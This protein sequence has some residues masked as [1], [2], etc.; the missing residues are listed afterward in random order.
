MKLTVAIPIDVDLGAYAAELRGLEQIMIDMIAEPALMHRL[1]THIREAVLGAIDQV[2]ATGLLT[3]NNSGAMTCSDPIGVP[4]NGR[5]TCRNLWCGASLETFDQVSP[6][7]WEEFGLNYQKPVCARF[8][9]VSYGCCESLTR[10]IEG[11]LSIPN[12]RIFTCTPWTNLPDVIEK[13]GNR[14]CIIWRHK[15]SN[16]VFPHDTAGIQA[17]LMD[18]ARRLQGC[19]YQV[20]L[21]GLQTL[22]GHADRLQVWTQLAKEAVSQ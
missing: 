8:G 6:M 1:M 12:L 5:Y 16:V 14:H 13:V 3:P 15:A 19:F 7:M 18:A 20:I 17:E 10:K 2:E 11:V 21:R 4:M 22:A 9:L